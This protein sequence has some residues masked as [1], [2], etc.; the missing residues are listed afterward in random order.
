MITSVPASPVL[1]INFLLGY[2]KCPFPMSSLFLSGHSNS[3]N[4]WSSNYGIAVA[5]SEFLEQDWHC[6]KMY[7]NKIYDK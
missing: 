4:K 1:A 3:G 2:K 6:D 7:Y 5:Q